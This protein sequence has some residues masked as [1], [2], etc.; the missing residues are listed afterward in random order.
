MSY[1]YQAALHDKRVWRVG[2]MLLPTLLRQVSGLMVQER[3]VKG[4]PDKNSL[5]PEALSRRSGVRLSSFHAPIF[6]PVASHAAH[7]S[8]SVQADK[9]LHGECS[10]GSSEQRHS[11]IKAAN[12]LKKQMLEADS[13][14]RRQMSRWFLRH[15]IASL[16][17]RGIEAAE[18]VP[19]HSHMIQL[20]RELLLTEIVRLQDIVGSQQQLLFLDTRGPPKDTTPGSVQKANARD[21]SEGESAM[22]NHEGSGPQ[23][24]RLR[25]LQDRLV[26]EAWHPA[27]ILKVAAEILLKGGACA[28]LST[29]AADERVLWSSLAFA[30]Q[31]EARLHAASCFENIKAD[32]C[33]IA[34][35]TED[36]VS[37]R[38]RSSLAL[39]ESPAQEEYKSYPYRENTKCVSASDAANCTPLRIPKGSISLNTASE[40]LSLGNGMDDVDAE[41]EAFGRR[42]QALEKAIQ[43]YLKARSS[44]SM[45]PLL[46]KWWKEEYCVLL[47]NCV[48]HLE[49]AAVSGHKGRITRNFRR[50]PPCYRAKCASAGQGTPPCCTGWWLP[51]HIRQRHEVLATAAGQ[52]SSSTL[53][54]EHVIALLQQVQTAKRSLRA[55]QS[56]ACSDGFQIDQ[57]EMDERAD[58]EA[59]TCIAEQPTDDMHLEEQVSVRRDGIGASGGKARGNSNLS[60]LPGLTLREDL[61]DL[62]AWRAAHLNES[63]VWSIVR[64]AGGLSSDAGALIDPLIGRAVYF[65]HPRVAALAAL[66]FKQSETGLIKTLKAWIDEAFAESW[67]AVERSDF[68][69]ALANASAAVALDGGKRVLLDMHSLIMLSERFECYNQRLIDLLAVA[70][71]VASGAVSPEPID[72]LAKTSS[73]GKARGGCASRG[74]CVLDKLPIADLKTLV[75]ALGR[76]QGRASH[77]Q[78]QRALCEVSVMLQY[79]S[80]LGPAVQA[81]NSLHDSE[82]IDTCVFVNF[83]ALT[84]SVIRRHLSLSHFACGHLL[85]GFHRLRHTDPLLLH[86]FAIKFQ[87]AAAHLYMER[88]AQ[89]Q[90]NAQKVLEQNHPTLVSQLSTNQRVVLNSLTTSV[91]HILPHAVGL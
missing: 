60:V 91:R 64:A 6:I 57:E 79:A 11:V 48:W 82:G 53:T 30:V 59:H 85:L 38:E 50:L 41:E 20:L 37:K 35:R 67:S 28:A 75:L 22:P 31:Q 8:N 23:L 54:T 42:T 55:T 9:A 74:C 69:C 80:E 3:S 45:F 40:N 88:Q 33:S 51:Q 66:I 16:L 27:I 24:K 34:S 62:L 77:P 19:Q 52:S 32:A 78:M 25:R 43:K 56:S 18:D 63:S 76:L 90:K 61:Q 70:V 10:V 49:A 29:S 2:A 87:R 46:P 1:L 26:D 47:Q 15:L 5:Q 71:H 7:C 58:S 21:I 36:D 84:A 68:E 13:Q 14:A 72:S 17:I 44:S 65:L 12:T 73:E 83:Q 4:D 89:E 81:T 86:H 39:A